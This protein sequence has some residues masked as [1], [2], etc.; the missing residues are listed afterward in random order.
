MNLLPVLARAFGVDPVRFEAQVEAYES[1]GIILPP[2]GD[3]LA[4]I[5]ARW[6]ERGCPDG[7]FAWLLAECKRLRAEVAAGLDEALNCGDGV[8]RP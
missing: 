1:P 2:A 3:R 5:E 7:D 6:R 4:L 8:Y